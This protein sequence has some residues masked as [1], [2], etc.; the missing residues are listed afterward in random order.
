[1]KL[2]YAAAAGSTFSAYSNFRP[3]VERRV[4]SRLPENV[5]ETC[6]E[7]CSG[8]KD[9][10]KQSFQLSIALYKKYNEIDIEILN[11]IFKKEIFQDGLRKFVP[12]GYELIYC[13]KEGKQPS[14]SC[15][16]KR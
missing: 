8:F 12:D 3:D 10:D 1:M 11:Q 14:L 2:S 9:S 13:H 5:F 6:K 4:V 16:R 7:I 15:I